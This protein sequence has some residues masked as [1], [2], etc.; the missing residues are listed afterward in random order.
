MK[1]IL[2]KLKQMTKNF[3]LASKKKECV[4]KNLLFLSKN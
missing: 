4:E 2:F 1:L 3:D